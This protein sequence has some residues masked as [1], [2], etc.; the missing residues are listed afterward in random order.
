MTTISDE[1]IV[2]ISTPIGVGG[3]GIVR[4]SG[5]RAFAIAGA[6]FRSQK[7]NFTFDKAESHRLY[8]GHAIDQTEQVIDE[9]LMSVFRSPHS[10]T[11]EDM[12]ELNAHG[13]I[14][15]L[16]QILERAL[17]LGARFAEPGE[18]TKRAFLNGRIDLTQAEAVLDT[19]QAKT[20]LALKAAMSQLHGSLSK[21]IHMIK[22]D[23]MRIYAH[24]EAFLDFPDD[25][26]EVY[27]NK[28]FKTRFELARTRLEKLLC[29]FTKG[30]IVREGLVAVIVGRPNVGKSSLLNAL[31]QRDRALVSE[32]PGTTRDTLEETI[33][34]DGI[35]IRLVDTAGLIS[36]DEP[37]T[38]ASMERTRQYFAEGD[39][40]LCVMDALDGF[41]DDDQAILN[42]VK[43]RRLI[44]VINKIDL[45][46]SGGKPQK[47]SEFKLPDGLVT[48]KPCFISAKLKTGIESLE[49]AIT[50]LV[51]QGK[52]DHA[53]TTITRLR[54][55]Q[56]AQASLEAL[57]RSEEAF[58][59]RKSLELVTLD[60]KQSL[61]ALREI[62]GEIYSEDL[63]D[64]IFKEFCIGK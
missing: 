11:R 63:L 9:V 30:E 22:D 43:S 49:E 32:V 15:G 17:G 19:I 8:F 44:P 47:A 26:L 57:K 21:E 53:S 60:L 41:T 28:E 39:L 34:L 27:A 7:K 56:A 61:D 18:F 36:S 62:V 23:L 51:W 38:K 20:D 42:E 35:S 50:A 25:D 29:S 24:M 13:G 2:A 64:V 40:F 4:L 12:I 46:P 48:E 33:L 3:I 10:Y 6:I 31:L 16:R 52:M 5:D 54:H 1:T 14:V 58:L 55:K 37:L 59:E 45:V